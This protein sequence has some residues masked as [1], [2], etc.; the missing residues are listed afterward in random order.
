MRRRTV[1]AAGVG[2]CVALVSS[3]GAATYP[4]ERAGAAKFDL[5]TRTGVV[6]YLE[7]LGLD[8]RRFVIQRGRLNYAGPNCP[9]KRWKCTRSR[10]V[11]QVSMG[12]RAVNR[13]EVSPAAPLDGPCAAFQDQTNPG[14]NIAKVKITSGTSQSCTIKQTST[15]GKNTVQV[16]EVVQ[17]TATTSQT[18]SQD[19]NVTQTSD[20]GSNTVQISQR[21][22]E[23]ISEPSATNVSESQESDQNF[24]VKQTSATGTNSSQV[25]QTLSQGESAPNATAGSQFQR[26]N[27]IGHVDQFSHALSTS[28]NTQSESQ[29][30]TAAAGSAVSQTQI[31]P[32]RCCTSQGDNP[33]DVFKIKQ[34]SSQTNNSANANT[35]YDGEATCATTGNCSASNTR[36]YNGVTTTNSASGSTVNIGTSCTDGSC[37]KGTPVPSGDLFVSV[38]DGKVQEWNVSG[39]PSL[40]RTLDTGMG[41]ETTGLAFD[42]ARNLLVTAF[43]ANNVAKFDSNGSLVGSFGTG[44]NAD[45][46]SIVFDAAGNAYVGQADGLADVLKFDAGGGALASFDV[47]REDRGSD[48]IALA[49]DGCTLFYTSE[50]S[51]V[52]R[53]NVCTTTQLADFATGVGCTGDPEFPTCSTAYGIRLLPDGGALVADSDA[54]RRLDS[55]GTVTQTYDAEGDD[56]WFSVALDPGGTAF[57]AGDGTTGDVR[58]FDLATGSVLK[59]FNTGVTSFGVRAGGI[60]IAP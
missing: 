1:L 53:F 18:A 48:H 30:Q 41:G 26:A 37:T 46:E 52:K 7:S 23:S 57:W 40:V 12:T 28:Q 3:V 21:V 22:T 60:A 10:Q 14:G 27:L 2:A 17:Q 54:V 39:V 5:A 56:L 38:S 33:G 59:S 55:A 49:A 24:S 43:T 19:A 15:T 29:A 8:A 25:S 9:G 13:F 32:T 47:A 6:R 44:Y 50:G 51:L 35:L 36:T 11:V 45:P 16:E 34:S 58:K 20:S 31:G 4:G 42:P